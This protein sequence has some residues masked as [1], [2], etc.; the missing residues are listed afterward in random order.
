MVAE[1]PE[2]PF[3]VASGEVEVRPV[4]VTAEKR[5]LDFGVPDA[6]RTVLPGHGR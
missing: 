5:R 2:I 1:G 6:H 4:F 3:A